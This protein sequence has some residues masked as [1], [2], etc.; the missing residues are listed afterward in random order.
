[1]LKVKTDAKKTMRTARTTLLIISVIAAFIARNPD[2]SVFGIVSFAWAGFGASFGPVVLFALFWR[3]SN[4]YGA[5][6]G[7]IAGGVMVFVWKYLVKPLGGIW[8]I[9]E[10]L[11]AFYSSMRCYHNCKPFN[12]SPVKRNNR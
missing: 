6:A 10:L 1:M 7:M 8:N 3:R 4:R 11:P 12:R 9:Y 2:S 5:M